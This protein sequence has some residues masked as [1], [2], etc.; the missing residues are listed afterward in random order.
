MAVSYTHL[1][2]YK[3]Q[4]F[5]NTLDPAVHPYFQTIAGL[6]VSAHLLI[7]R[8]G[9]LTQ[10]APFHC[11]A[12]H[13]GPSEYAGRSRCND[14]S[15]GIELEGAD[16]VSYTHLDVYKRQAFGPGRHWAGTQDLSGAGL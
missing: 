9:D 15:I 5:T 3:R 6:R 4:L 14:F 12:W 16:P 2:V 8:D 7:R 13:A 1:D 10:Y 11:R